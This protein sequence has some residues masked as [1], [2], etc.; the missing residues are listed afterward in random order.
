MKLRHLP[1]LLALI[2]SALFADGFTLHST[3]LSGQLSKTQE[4]ASFGC[5]GSNISPALS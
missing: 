3:D 1:I 5:D 2:G 4:A